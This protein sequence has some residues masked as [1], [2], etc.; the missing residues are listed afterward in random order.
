MIKF[1]LIGFGNGILFG[2]LDAVLNANPIAQKALEAYKPILKASVNAPAGILIDLFYGFALG[3]IFL[4]LYRPGG[5]HAAGDHLLGRR[6]QG[7]HPDRPPHGGRCR[8]SQNDGLP[9]L[10]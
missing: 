9:R 1:I 7:T 2:L 4:I 8:H 10:D 3:F 6:G 5:D